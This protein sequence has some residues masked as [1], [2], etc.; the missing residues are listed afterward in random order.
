[1][2]AMKILGG[3]VVLLLVVALLFAWTLPADVGYRYAARWLGPVAL[4]GLSGTVWDGHADGA[5]VFGVDL[6]ELDWHARRLPI[7]GGRF[8]ADVRIKG[9]DI[10]AA[11]ELSRGAGSIVAREVRFSL[12]AA[13]LEPMLDLDGLHLVGTVEGVIADAALTQGRLAAASGTA[14]WT[15]AGVTGGAEARF[16]DILLDFA[17]QPGGGIA[18]SV[19]DDGRGNLAVS[20][21]FVAQLAAFDLEVDLRARNGDAQVAEMLRRV[22]APQPDGSSKLVVH[23]PVLKLF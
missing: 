18:G 20:G 15:G 19:H 1:M 12:P 11:G 17:A 13:I 5:S 22:G 8:V 10:D 23:G 6:G 2:R 7:L 16:S 21:R 3:V 4:S 9:A 14:R